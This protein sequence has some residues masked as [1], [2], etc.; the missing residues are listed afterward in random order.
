MGERLF[1]SIVYRILRVISTLRSKE[2][3]VKIWGDIASRFICYESLSELL[4]R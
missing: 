4:E 2:E 1:S 3:V